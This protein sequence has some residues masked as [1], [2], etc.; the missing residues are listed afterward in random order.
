MTRIRKVSLVFSGIVYL[1]G[2]SLSAM[3]MK[4]NEPAKRITLV[5]ASIGK[6]WNFD[7]IT[8]RL[9]LPGY[10]FKYVG[11]YNFDKGPLIDTIVG[12]PQKPDFVMIK[13]C[14][15]YFP[16]DM[17]KY[18][19]SI[20]SWVGKLRVT[21]IQ[22]VLLTVAPVKEPG[23][24]Q[25][26]KNAVKKAMGRPIWPEEIAAFNDWLRTYAAREGVPLFDLEQALW[27]APD[28][29]YLKPEFTTDDD[30][31]LNRAAYQ[32]VDREF[33]RFISTLNRLSV[34]R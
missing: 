17:G 7:R 6:D 15:S 23:M 22:P 34:A 9:Q 25:R 30:I 19:A 28:R 11:T 31:H 1:M 4:P 3:A 24:V 32:Q 33:E 18:Q 14:S 5:G 26:A 20:Q 12:Q 8:E 2:A 29:R 13:E 27:I 10:D 21:G 16:G